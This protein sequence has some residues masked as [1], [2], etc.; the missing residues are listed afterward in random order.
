MIHLYLVDTRPK[1]YRHSADTLQTLGPRPFGGHRPFLTFHA[2]N[3][4]LAHIFS[5]VITF[6]YANQLR[7]K[8]MINSEVPKYWHSLLSE[9]AAPGSYH[10]LESFF[11]SG[12]YFWGTKNVG[13]TARLFFQFKSMLLPHGWALHV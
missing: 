3:I 7:S 5:L 2:G 4:H 12:R 1:L 6:I 13:T 11:S 9:L 8:T 10:F